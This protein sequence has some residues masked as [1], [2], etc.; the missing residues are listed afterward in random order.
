M[1][2]NRILISSV[3]LTI[4]LLLTARL[5]TARTEVVLDPS[6]D[7]A[8]VMENQQSMNQ[9]KA[10]IPSYRSALDECFDVSL[11]EVTICRAANQVPVPSY[12]SPL[13]E[14]FDVSLREVTSCRNA[15]QA[16]A[17]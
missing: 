8:A 3:V 2:N 10:P 12:R 11:M 4:I 16:S 13:D 7:P 1:L 6:N 5:V 15:S 9:N 17:P 14:C